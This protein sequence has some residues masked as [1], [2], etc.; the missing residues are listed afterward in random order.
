MRNRDLKKIQNIELAMLKQ[1]HSICIE[2]DLEYFAV[3]GTLL[4]AVRHQGFIPWDDDIDLAMPRQDFE[5]FVQIAEKNLPSHMKLSY[6]ELNLNTLQL[7]D[8]RTKVIKGKKETPLYIDIFPLDGFPQRKLVKF[9]HEKQI[10]F[11]RMLCKLSVV[12][13]MTDRD[14]GVLENFIVKFGK[15]IK[16]DRILSTKKELEKL[17]SVVKRYSYESSILCGNVLGRYREKEIVEKSIFGKPTIKQFET[18]EIYCPS[19]TEAYLS[20]IYGDFM[21]LPPKEE[22]QPQNLTIVSLGEHSL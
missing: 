6:S 10:L 22:Q 2:N 17:H 16:T 20:A 8:T 9:L 11:Q 1:F 19:Q 15:I 7:T 12:N 14:R 3:G 5:R 18:I 4:G 21:K 13:T